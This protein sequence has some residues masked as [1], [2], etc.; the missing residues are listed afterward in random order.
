MNDYEC[1]SAAIRFL[2]ERGG[3]QADLAMVSAQIGLSPSCFQRR[4]RAWAGGAPKD[5][6]QCLTLSHARDLMR[7]GESVLDEGDS[8]LVGLQDDCTMLA[9]ATQG[10]I[11]GRGA[12][13]IIEA[14]VVDG[15]FGNALIG[16]TARGICHLSFFDQGKREQ[17]IADMRADW[18]LAE[19]RWN[20]AHAAGLAE[21][22]FHPAGSG[23][24]WKLFVRGTP[25]QV[26]V[27]RALMKVQPGMLVSYSNLARAAGYPNAA[28]AT[29]SAV[30]S[31][32]ISF[33]I[34]CHRV[35]R[36]SGVSGD[37]RWGALRKRVILAWECGR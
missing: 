29:G 33:L 30:G 6:L 8:G 26:C 13:M 28:R 32:A 23:G 37:Y 1:V 3:A 16:E 21:R 34:P 35:V 36:E 10:E 5:I 12:G 9:V 4:F 25:F 2:D 22:I 14:G 19:L 11:K 31:N 7:R 24:S 20:D 17:A 18:P 15:P 27:W